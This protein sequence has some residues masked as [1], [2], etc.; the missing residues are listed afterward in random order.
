MVETGKRNLKDKLLKIILLVIGIY[1]IIFGLVGFISA[2][3]AVRIAKYVFDMNITLTD[4]SAYLATLL[5]AYAFVFGLFTFI[6]AL[7]PQKYGYVVYIGSV[8]YLLRLIHRIMFADVVRDAFN[9]SAFNRIA[10]IILLVFFA[11][12]LFLLRLQTQSDPS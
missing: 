4:Q 10:E 3:F 11:V 7:N 6:A 1:H 2:E 12:A 8:L 5:G 9:V